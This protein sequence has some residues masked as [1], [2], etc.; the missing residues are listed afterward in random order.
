[1]SA[2]HTCR[3]FIDGAWVEAADGR[4]LESFDPCRGAPWAK[5]PRSGADD[6][7]RAVSAASAA[8]A[9]GP[10]RK[11]TATE[12]G[13]ALRRV[14]ELILRDADRLAQIETRD[15]GKLLSEMAAQVRY[16]AQWYFYYGGLADKIEGAVLPSD[17]PDMVNF[18]RLEPIGPVLAITAWNSPL[19]LAAYKVAP[20]LAA[21]N[22][23][24]IKPSEHASASTLE[25]ARLFEEAGIP[26]GTVNVVSGLGA[27]VGAALAAD[28]RIAKVSYT[29]GEQVG[30]EIASQAARNLRGAVLELGG[31]SPNI[32]FEDA[33]LDSAVN[34]A[35]AGIFAASGQTCVA[36]SRL[37]LQET[38][39]D[40]FMEKLLEAACSITVGDPMKAATNV[41]PIAT[42]AQ[43]DLIL[44]YLE[45]ARQEGAKCVLG[46]ERQNIPQFPE[47]WFV[48]PTIF[49]DVTNTMRIAREEVFGPVLSVLRF[50]DEAEALSIANDSSLGLAAGVW[51]RDLNRALRMSADLQA[52]TVWVN[53][54]R[55][56]SFLSP[57]GGYKDSGL[58]RENGAEAIKQY[59]QTKSVW[60]STGGAATNPFVIR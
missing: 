50:K 40:A 46:G 8:F 57:F 45:V 27:E 9:N 16:T 4:W 6:A 44:G 10:W 28:P 15:N 17:K 54:F 5:I 1:M 51:T 32:V 20:A 23:V 56:V 36:G 58:G 19:L 55:A 48:Q 37:L 18:T 26:P 47:G 35:I 38:I 2:L 53:T 31:K 42:R 21:G 24:I 29:G 3:Q 60:I 14:G 12:R 41:G 34:G 52:G 43:L 39:H 30:R 7:D 59:L 33:D 25:F 22:T 11:M 13:A 49:T